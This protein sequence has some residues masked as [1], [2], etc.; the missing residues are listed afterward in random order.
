MQLDPVTLVVNTRSHRYVTLV[1]GKDLLP[2][3]SA[4]A[5]FHSRSML[6]RVGDCESSRGLSLA[7]FNECCCRR[8]IDT[9][10]YVADANP[11]T[12]SFC[13]QSCNSFET[14]TGRNRP[15]RH[16]IL[17]KAGC[18]SFCMLRWWMQMQMWLRRKR[19]MFLRPGYEGFG[20]IFIII[21]SYCW[22]KIN[23]TGSI[24]KCDTILTLTF[25]ASILWFWG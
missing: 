17:R 22:A 23:P 18:K 3:G 20:S 12:L 21:Y 24:F 2:L 5:C 7:C 14:R 9:C 10:C 25:G 6:G 15:A 16:A 1:N 19:R 4:A 11:Q 13:L 8:D